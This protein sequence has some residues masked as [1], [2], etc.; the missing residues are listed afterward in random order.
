MGKRIQVI[1]GTFC[2]CVGI[3]S[4]EEYWQ[5]WHFERLVVFLSF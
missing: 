2:P 1:D 3:F 4:G 5:G